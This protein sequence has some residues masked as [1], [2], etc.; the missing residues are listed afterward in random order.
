MKR[1]LLVLALG[2]VAI[3]LL[4]ASAPGHGPMMNPEKLDKYLTFRINDLLDDLKAT[5]TQRSQ[6]LAVKDRLLPEAQKMMAEHKQTH[7][8][9]LQIWKSDRP[10]ANALHALV[11]Q[12]VDA[13]RA[14]AH[15]LADGMLDVHNAL[16]PAQ[17]SQLADELAKQGPMHHHRP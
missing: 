11:D 3:G 12:R 7:D 10:D 15:K 5:P 8:Q 17:R 1:T 6:V 4:A 16:T 14:F 13:F 2:V 9:L